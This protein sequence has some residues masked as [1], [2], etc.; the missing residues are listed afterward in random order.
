MEITGTITK[1]FPMQ[2]GV[3]KNGNP[4]TKRDIIVEYV[5]GEYPK[6]I[7][8]SVL[9]EKVC[10]LLKEEMDVKVQFD[11]TVRTWQK[12][13]NSEVRYFNEP[14]IWKDG[15]HVVRAQQPQSQPQ[16]AYT[17]QQNAYAQ[18]VVPA[19]APQLTTPVQTN[20]NDEDVP[21]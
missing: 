14:R 5:H 11:F 20:V 4:W 16:Q 17:P 10:P 2:N 9:D 7:L 13:Q 18:P 19:Q 21:F 1:V 12:D 8:L 6:Q 3:S 15:I